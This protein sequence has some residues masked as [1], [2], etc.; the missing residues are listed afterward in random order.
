MLRKCIKNLQGIFFAAHSAVFSVYFHIFCRIFANISFLFFFCQT[1]A[2]WPQGQDTHRCTHMCR[3]CVCV[4]CVGC[5]CAWLGVSAITIIM[6]IMHKLQNSAA[7]RMCV[8]AL[9]VCVCG[10]IAH[11]CVCVCLCVCAAATN[12]RQPQI[13]A[14]F[15]LHFPI[16]SQ[17]GVRG[18]QPP[19]PPFLAGRHVCGRVALFYSLVV[20]A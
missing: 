17:N 14:V 15:S 5:V 13:A 8:A 10:S 9:C 20:F 6:I 11:V 4:V 18:S 7:S 1:P 16:V 2:P 3:C 19:S 12:E